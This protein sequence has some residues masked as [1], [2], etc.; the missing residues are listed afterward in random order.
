MMVSGGCERPS[1]LGWLCS[2][3]VVLLQRFLFSSVSGSALQ[4]FIL[5]VAIIMGGAPF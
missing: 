2:S 4:P 5:A 3:G 1:L